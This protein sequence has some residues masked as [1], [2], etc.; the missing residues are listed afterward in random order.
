MYQNDFFMKRVCF[1]IKAYC[2][3]R[4]LNRVSLR[5]QG[6]F[7]VEML[8]PNKTIPQI[9]CNFKNQYTVND[10]RVVEEVCVHRQNV[11]K[12]KVR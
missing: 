3:M 12:Y 6:E 1:Y 7:P 5:F 8:P 4:L 2:Q 10:Y 11:K 9:I